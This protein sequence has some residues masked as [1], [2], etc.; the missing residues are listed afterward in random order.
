MFTFITE[1]NGALRMC[2]SPA[3]CNSHLCCGKL[4]PK[5]KTCFIPH[6]DKKKSFIQRDVF[7]LCETDNS[8]KKVS[9]AQMIIYSLLASCSGTL[10]RST[11][12]LPA[13]LTASRDL[14]AETCH[15]HLIVW[16]CTFFQAMWQTLNRLSRDGEWPTLTK[17]PVQWPGVA[18]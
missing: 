16:L 15:L 3:A 13:I 12:R 17:C 4:M 10:L 1:E 14:T 5:N 8:E 6:A 9:E 7:L 18:I 2:W 11:Q